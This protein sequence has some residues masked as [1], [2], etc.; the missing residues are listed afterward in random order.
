MI[1]ADKWKDRHMD[2][3]FKGVGLGLAK[4]VSPTVTSLTMIYLL[5]PVGLL[6]CDIQDLI[7][8]THHLV[9]SNSR[10]KDTELSLGLKGLICNENVI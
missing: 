4:G 9:S 10:C 6:D 1:L 3:G 2:D 8:S 5:S 7:P